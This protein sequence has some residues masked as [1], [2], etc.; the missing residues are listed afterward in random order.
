VEGSS[1]GRVEPGRLLGVSCSE[2]IEFME[3]ETTG[4]GT[5]DRHAIEEADEAY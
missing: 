3:E 1:N 2:L 4:L 5:L